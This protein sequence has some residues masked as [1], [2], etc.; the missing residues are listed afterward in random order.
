MEVNKIFTLNYNKQ[1]LSNEIN[2]LL[3]SNGIVKV[4]NFPIESNIELI[5]L[6]KALGEPIEPKAGFQ[7]GNIEDIYI[8][9][10]Q[11]SPVGNMVISQT[12]EAFMF[13]TDGFLSEIV[14]DIVILLA[15]VPAAVGGDS[16]F[17]HVN[18]L[19]K[20]LP[21]NTIIKLRKE[22]Y[23]YANG[24][25]ERRIL[26]VEDNEYRIFYNPYDV[27]G[28]EVQ[29]RG[30]YK[31]AEVEELLKKDFFTRDLNSSIRNCKS[32]LNTKLETGDC[33]IFKNH[34]YL[35]SRE[36]FSGDRLFKRVWVAN[37]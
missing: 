33:I 21:E 13:H 34:S 17:I 11:P 26:T 16:S 27:A 35:H 31:S 22:S 28:I 4:S 18:E 3:H 2:D 15:V 25:I 19:T 5:E 12:R 24:K 32:V 37:K 1:S 20:K 36:A 29:K 8:Y 14:P 23:Q 6:A 7:K 10:V 30:L 9:R